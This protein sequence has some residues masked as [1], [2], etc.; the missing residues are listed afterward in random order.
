[1]NKN[2]YTNI[3]EDASQI[4][5]YFIMGLSLLLP[6]LVYVFIR[7]IFCDVLHLNHP[8]M[9]PVFL[10]MIANLLAVVYLHLLD[11]R[12]MKEVCGNVDKLLSTVF[13]FQP[14]Y[15]VFREEMLGKSK[16]VSIIYAVVSVAEIVLV[17][18]MYVWSCVRDVLEML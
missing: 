1:M 10:M 14:L 18:G 8:P 9:I 2:R 13:I 5:A 3:L 15:F 6:I 17:L 7:G 12:Y 4:R 16:K 11:Y